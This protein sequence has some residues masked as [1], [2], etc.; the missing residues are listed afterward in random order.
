[1]SHLLSDG[2]LHAIGS[3]VGCECI[4]FLKRVFRR[5][6]TMTPFG[7]IIANHQEM[8]ECF[9]EAVADMGSTAAYLGK[10][11]EQMRK[12]GANGSCS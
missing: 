4:P 1:M 12:R 2:E 8:R 9:A 3:L 5:R 7:I 6:A 10:R 11:L